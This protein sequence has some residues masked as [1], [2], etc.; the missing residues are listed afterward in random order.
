MAAVPGLTAGFKF[1]PEDKEVIELYLL[2]SLRREPVPLDGVLIVDD[3]LETPPWD[4]FSRHNLGEAK[5]AYF[6]APGC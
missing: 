4:L 6:L 3:P 1:K 2:P 5:E